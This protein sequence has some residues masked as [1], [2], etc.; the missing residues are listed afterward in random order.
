M[1]RRAAHAA[2]FFEGVKP[3]VERIVD[4]TLDQPAANPQPAG[5]VPQRTGVDAARNLLRFK[6]LFPALPCR[7]NQFLRTINRSTSV[8]SVARERFHDPEWAPRTENG[9]QSISHDEDSS[10]EMD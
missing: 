2:V 8:S 6:P 9:D 5:T 10:V 7:S 3:I 4:L 1:P